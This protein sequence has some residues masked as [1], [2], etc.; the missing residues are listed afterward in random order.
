[1]AVDF[2]KPRSAKID[3][4]FQ[5][6]AQITLPTLST[7]GGGN[8]HLCFLSHP[9][10]KPDMDRAGNQKLNE[11]GEPVFLHIAT[12]FDLVDKMKAQ[13]VL[14]AVLKSELELHYPKGYCGVCFEISVP[15]E[16]A[17]NKKYKIPQLWEDHTPDWL[18]DELAKLL[19]PTSLK[20]LAE[21]NSIRAVLKEHNEK[22][23]LE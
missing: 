9:I 4:A 16:K 19:P 20:K 14:G 17:E 22:K 3:Q 21:L 1:M 6:K 5:R 2:S 18:D 12:V 10:A 13:F 7:R 15:K 11:E 8:F 23:N